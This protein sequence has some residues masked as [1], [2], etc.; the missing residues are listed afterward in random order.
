[1]TI[2]NCEQLVY[3]TITRIHR[4]CAFQAATLFSGIIGNP[5]KP[6]PCC[7]LLIGLRIRRPQHPLQF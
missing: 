2:E 6:E 7:R 3:L 1:M 5:A 4:Q